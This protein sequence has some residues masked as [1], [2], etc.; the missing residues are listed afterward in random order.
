MTVSDVFPLVFYVAILL[1][2]L[3]SR[4]WSPPKY[5]QEL[6]NSAYLPLV[7]FGYSVM[8]Y[9]DSLHPF[10]TTVMVLATAFSAF[11]LSILIDYPKTLVYKL[12][13]NDA[14]AIARL[15]EWAA[16]NRKKDPNG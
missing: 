11:R 4:R 15:S 1:Y 8:F 12:D 14:M 7:I 5:Y 16:A 3:A 10:T 2:F 9:E 6:K 13:R